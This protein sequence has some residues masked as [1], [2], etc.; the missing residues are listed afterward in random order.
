MAFPTAV[1]AIRAINWGRNADDIVDGDVAAP[2]GDGIVSSDGIRTRRVANVS[3]R[4]ESSQH[5]LSHRAWDE[6]QPAT[7]SIFDGHIAEP[8]ERKD[9]CVRQHGVDSAAIGAGIELRSI[10]SSC[11]GQRRDISGVDS[12]DMSGGGGNQRVW[13]GD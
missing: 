7:K 13:V 4:H 12:G 5:S 11:G 10:S 9:D 8:G 3:Q 2:A 1:A 6:R